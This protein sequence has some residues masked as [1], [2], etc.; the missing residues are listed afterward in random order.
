MD[1]RFTTNTIEVR[2]IVEMLREGN[3]V[4]DNSY[5][6]RIIWSEKDKVC[7][8]ETILL[9]LVVPA[10]Y[11]W[12]SDINPETG[13]AKTHIVDGQQRIW[14][15]QNFVDGDLKLKTSLLMNNEAKIRFG[16]CSFADLEIDLKNAFWSYRLSVIEIDRSATINAIKEM[17]HRLNL[18][19]YNL[20]AQ[21]KRHLNDGEFAKL[22][23]ELAVNNFW[24]DHNIF[25]G[26]E[27]RRMGDIEFCANLILLYKRG[28]VDQTTQKT[29]NEAYEDYAIEYNE[30]AKDGE[31]I[32]EAIGLI[33]HFI[34]DDTELFLR[35]K[36][37][38]YSLFSLLF[39]LMR[40][41]LDVKYEEL[42]E[43]LT[44]FA[45]V[46]NNFK[47]YEDRALQLDDS[48][49]NLYEQIKIYRLASS[50]GVNKQ[51]NRM[52]RLKVLQKLLLADF[53]GK[54]VY[55]NLEQ[56]LSSI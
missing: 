11:F 38:L 54:E 5:Q 28:I 55:E 36:T 4:V 30:V 39:F 21:E 47:N 44:Y 46:Y 17:F 7:L 49:K 31:K 19:D 22:A 33:E 26:R 35:R 50:E 56:K 48:E 52:N 13:K 25:S 45:K 3:L 14:A 37:Q 12:N 6:R 20:N 32:Q 18:T 43:R 15:L 42:A 40:E 8:I 1:F 53:V 2:T 27:V 24:D 10:V 9:N 29:L 23:K 16:D 34:N 51:T 41:K